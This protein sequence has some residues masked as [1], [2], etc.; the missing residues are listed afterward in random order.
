VKRKRPSLE[1][2][3]QQLSEAAADPH[4]H[5]QRVRDALA[6][7]R[8]RVAARAA[9]LVKQHT[10]DGFEA[11]LQAA[12]RRFRED[13]VKSDPSCN[14]KL[15]A[16]EALDFG[17]S[18]DEE[19]FLEAARLVQLEPAW[20]KPVD[21]A[22]GVR[23]RGLVALARIG[24]VEL[25]LLAAELLGDQEPPVRHAALEALA[26]RGAR[27]GA[28]L[29]LFKL[30]LGDEDPLVTLAA[31][32]TLLQLAPDWGL[33]E[34]RPILDGKDEERELAALALGQSRSE[35]ALPLLLAA[36]EGCVMSEERAPIYRGLGFH[37]S[38]AALE[39]LLEVIAGGSLP[40]AKQAIAALSVRRYDPGVVEKVR[41]AAGR[42][43]LAGAVEENF[44]A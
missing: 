16:L 11:D 12:F 30:R 23:S 3:Q 13:P 15:A 9:R 33:R 8:S 31:M 26:H 2:E 20:G 44:S 17:E 41:R 36:L 40:D 25:D 24:W 28:A 29:A 37:R 18:M 27:S 35:A 34:L 43:A 38:D 6:S 10:L 4:A 39:K 14:A 42:E 21:T 7:R 5:L 32:N 1:D 22:V 19:I